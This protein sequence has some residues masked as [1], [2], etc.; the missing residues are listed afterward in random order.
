MAKAPSWEFL[1]W[2]CHFGTYSRPNSPISTW[3]S[4]DKMAKIFKR[5]NHVTIFGNYNFG[6]RIKGIRS[7]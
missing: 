4:R 3:K 2:D 6:E 5:Q 1:S 7:S